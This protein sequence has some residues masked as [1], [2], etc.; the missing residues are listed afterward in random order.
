MLQGDAYNIPVTISDSE[1]L[2][3]TSMMVQTIEIMIG[4]L[5][6]TYPDDISYS[7][8][9]WLFPLTQTESMTLGGRESVQVRVKFNDGSV[10]GWRG[11][12][13]DVRKSV[14]KV[15]L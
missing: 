7:D 12:G 6:K 14:S 5:R 2:V 8:G 10:I 4:A 15:V 11:D 3:V 9:Q 13:I 1:G